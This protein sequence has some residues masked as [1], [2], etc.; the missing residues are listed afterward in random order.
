M[1]IV[2]EEKDNYCRRNITKKILRH[3]IRSGEE[4]ENRGFIYEVKIGIINNFV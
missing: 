4:G 1:S 3:S 2:N